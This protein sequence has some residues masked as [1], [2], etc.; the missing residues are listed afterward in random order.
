MN[1]YRDERKH[2]LDARPGGEGEEHGGVGAEERGERGG[3]DVAAQQRHV[4]GQPAYAVRDAVHAAGGGALDLPDL[5]Q[6][7][8]GRQ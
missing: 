3:G 6:G 8:V 5:V 4:D 7:C 2:E 1:T